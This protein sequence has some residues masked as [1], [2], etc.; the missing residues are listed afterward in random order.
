MALARFGARMRRN[1]ARPEV[2]ERATP[3]EL[4]DPLHERYCFTIDA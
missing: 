1:G 3:P 2:D 4:F